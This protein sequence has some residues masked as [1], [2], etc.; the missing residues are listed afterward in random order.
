V[1]WFWTM[2]LIALTACAVLV[3]AIADPA[4]LHT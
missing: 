2:V 1:V 4:L 3:L